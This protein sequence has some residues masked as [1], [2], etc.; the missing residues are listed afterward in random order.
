MVSGAIYEEPPCLAYMLE[1]PLLTWTEQTGGGV[2][3]HMRKPQYLV[4]LLDFTL[5]GRSEVYGQRSYI[6]RASMSGPSA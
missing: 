1:W 4:D 2:L 6:R 3:R 5:P